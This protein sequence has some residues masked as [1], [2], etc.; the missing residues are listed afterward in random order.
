MSSIVTNLAAL[1]AQRNL[2]IT[3]MKTG[4]V[5]EKLSSG[6]RI[7]RAADDAAGL[8]ISEKMRAQIRGNTQAIRNAQDGVSMIQTAEGAMDEVHSI[9][10]RMRELGVQAANDTNDTAARDSVA[11]EIN[12]LRTEIDRIANGTQFNGQNLLTGSLGTAGATIDSN[13]ANTTVGAGSVAAQA[14]VGGDMSNMQIGKSITSNGHFGSITGITLDA[15]AQDLLSTGTWTLGGGGDGTTA[16]ALTLTHTDPNGGPTVVLTSGVPAFDAA[17]MVF[18]GNVVVAG[19]NKAVNVT[20]SA[21]LG[22]LGTAGEK[23]QALGG[24][25]NLVL[26]DSATK[27]ATVQSVSATAAT[28]AGTYTFSANST[29]NQLNVTQT[30]PNGTVVGTVAY[31]LGAL[32]AGTNTVAIGT[33]GI[34]LTINAGTGGVTADALVHDLVGKKVT[35]NP[36]IVGANGGAVLQIGANTSSYD[37]MTINFNDVQASTVTGLNL[38]NQTVTQAANSALSGNVSVDFGTVTGTNG[39]VGTN[40]RAQAFI[41]IVDNAITTLNSRRANLGATQNRLEH[42]VNSLGVSVENLTASESRIRDADVASLS[43]QMVSNQVLSQA[44]T[45][46]LSQANQSAQGVLALLR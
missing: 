24:A 30:A 37:E 16:A 32:A 13:S 46:V 44:G 38:A 5:F 33:S 11:T 1:N 9:L 43:T 12:Q 25:G 6:F 4:K 8:G 7:N 15:N 42:T 45:A 34:S 22:S 28:S 39:I 20:V 3:G 31:T 35:V 36:G 17:D 10:Q 26:A 2:G 19:V 41:S 18:T 14:A 29:L 21:S 27:T 23:G 40:D